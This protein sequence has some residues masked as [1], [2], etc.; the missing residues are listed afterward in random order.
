MSNFSLRTADHPQKGR[1]L[2]SLSG[3]SF[4]DELL[5][6][7]LGIYD[8]DIEALACARITTTSTSTLLT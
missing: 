7:K 2:T 6:E 4:A 3:I 5:L 1:G 8:A